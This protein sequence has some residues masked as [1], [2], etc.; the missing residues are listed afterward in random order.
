VLKIFTPYIFEKTLVLVSGIN[1]NGISSINFKNF[2]AEMRPLEFQGAVD[3]FSSLFFLFLLGFCIVFYNYF[4]ERKPEYLLLIIWSSVAFLIT[5]IITFFGQGRFDIYFS[6][7]VALLAGFIIVRGI[8]FGWK[9]LNISSRLDESNSFKIYFLVGSLAIL[10]GLVFLMIYPFPFNA[11]LSGNETLPDIVQNTLSKVGRPYSLGQDWYVALRWLKEKTPD[12]GL[13]FYDLYREPGINKK[14]GEANLYQYPASAYGV[15]SWWDFGYAILYYAHRMPIADPGQRGIGRIENGQVKEVG[16]GVFLLETDEAKAVSYL[17]ELKAK[18][19]LTDSNFSIMESGLFNVMVKWVQG[20]MDGY[21]DSPEDSLTKYDNAMMVRLHLLDGSE[22]TIVKKVSNNKNIDLDVGALTHFRLLYE[23]PT[24]ARLLPVKDSTRDLKRVKV[25]EY[26]KG[27]KIRGRAVSGTKIE[28][29][30][31]ISTNQQ[32]NFAYQ[33]SIVSEDGNF[34]FVVPY[35]TGKQE[36]SDVSAGEYTIKIGS[37][38]KNIKV[39]EDDILQ[40]KIVQV[41]F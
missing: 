19:I 4:K 13:G 2:I 34:E 1:N 30:T 5:G 32:R 38:T 40:G 16:A 29:S 31:Q 22:T 25:F 36:N 33:N 24:T 8:E 10:S 3:D 21:L 27:A 41:N 23:S 18:Y 9:S 14:T 39:S 11:G 20:N 37:R 26:V 7:C 15:L 35:S 12:P 6:V 17:D 28:I